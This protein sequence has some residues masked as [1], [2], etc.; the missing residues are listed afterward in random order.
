MAW[1]DTPITEEIAADHDQMRKII[2]NEEPKWAPGTKTGYH[3]YTYGWLVDQI[4]RH[5]DGR[6][7]G[8]GQFFRE[9][10]ATKLGL[11]AL[12]QQRKFIKLFQK[13]T[14]ISDSHSPSNIELHE[15]VLQICSID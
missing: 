6:K 10:I 14:I 15:S 11:L 3:A 1:F 8:I 12:K 13:L 7:R 4:V 2:E 5:T 9:E